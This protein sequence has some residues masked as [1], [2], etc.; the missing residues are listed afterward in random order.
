MRSKGIINYREVICEFESE[1]VLKIIQREPL[2]FCFDHIFNLDT[3][4]KDVYE[5][6]ARP[7][8]DSTI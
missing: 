2:L 6:A 8:V 3:L 1:K 5:I 4:Q 7:L